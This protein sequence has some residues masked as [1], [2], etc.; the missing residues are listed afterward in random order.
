MTDAEITADADAL[1]A[2]DD[3]NVTYAVDVTLDGVDSLPRLPSNG[4]AYS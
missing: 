4:T 2:N 1:L 3:N